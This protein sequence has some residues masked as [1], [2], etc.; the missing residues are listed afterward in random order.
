[1][2][3]ELAPSNQTSNQ[4]L[5]FR[6][7]AFLLFGGVQEALGTCCEIRGKIITG[8]FSRTIV[9]WFTALSS[10]VVN[11]FVSIFF[12]IPKFN[13][14]FVFFMKAICGMQ[15]QYYTAAKIRP[16]TA[17]DFDLIWWLPLGSFGKGL[18]KCCE[19]RG[20]NHDRRFSRTVA[21]RFIAMNSANIS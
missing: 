9:A 6:P 5:P 12:W 3:I 14:I 20:K 1:M 2:T 13:S 10:A 19:T 15:Y 18:G 16:S 4:L 11:L 8:W 17:A 7:C 21:A